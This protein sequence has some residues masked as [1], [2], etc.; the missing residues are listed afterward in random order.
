MGK[1]LKITDFEFLDGWMFNFERCFGFKSRVIHDEAGSAVINAKVQTRVT[2]VKQKIMYG[3][4]NVY[5][6]HETALFY[7]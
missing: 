6:F 1:A 4:S 7:A 3:L 5:N 2:E